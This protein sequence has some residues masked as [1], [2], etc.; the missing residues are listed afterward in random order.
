MTLTS[1]RSCSSWGCSPQ[2]QT[3]AASGPKEGLPVVRS[4]ACVACCCRSAVM[5]AGT[6]L[7]VTRCEHLIDGY[8]YVTW[9]QAASKFADKTR[10]PHV[11]RMCHSNEDEAVALV[12][13]VADVV[14][15]TSFRLVHCN[16]SYCRYYCDNCRAACEAPALP[17][18]GA[19]HSM[20][21]CIHE[22]FHYI[23]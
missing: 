10:F 22:V 16:D 3:S 13:I 2:P 18:C 6:P 23:V 21:T 1:A 14:Q 8:V 9:P 4:S 17:C 11:S 19:L 20:C 7:S 15:H 12:D 5:F